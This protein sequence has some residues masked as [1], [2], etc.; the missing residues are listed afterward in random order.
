MDYLDQILD[1]NTQAAII[2]PVQTSLINGVQNA[3]GVKPQEQKQLEPTSVQ[4]VY[5][6]LQTQAGAVD[7]SKLLSIGLFASLAAAAGYIVLRKRK[8]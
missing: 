3:L 4:S 7:Q 6:T 8:A 2:K 5:E 1:S